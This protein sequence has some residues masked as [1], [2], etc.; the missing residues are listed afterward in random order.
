[1]VAIWLALHQGAG[2]PAAESFLHKGVPIYTFAWQ[3]NE[4][5]SGDYLT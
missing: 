4:Q 3:G 2:S 5:G 1:M